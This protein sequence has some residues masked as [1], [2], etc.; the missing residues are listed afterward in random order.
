MAAFNYV[1]FIADCPACSTS[2]TIRAQF[3]VAS[4]Y[5]GDESGRFFGRTYEIGDIVRWWPPDDPRF[6]DWKESA[7]PARPNEV[8]EACYAECESCKAEL[9]A[10]VRFDDDVRIAAFEHISIEAE[11]PRGY[12]K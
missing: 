10:V 9:C 3:H 5:D 7:D 6:D 4:A 2:S 11:W 1:V 12:L 8:I